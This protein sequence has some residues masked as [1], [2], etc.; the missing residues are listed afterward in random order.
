MRT[1]VIRFLALACASS[2]ALALS[3]NALATPRLIISGGSTPGVA[4]ATTVQVTEDKTD[5]APLKITIYQ[6]TGYTATLGQPAG[7]QIGTVHADL[8]ALAI[9]P[10]A[11]IQADGTVLTANPATYTSN[12]CAPGNHA[13]VWLLHVTV[14]GQTID[15]PVYLD[16]TTGAEAALG[17]AKLQLCLSDPYDTAPA[18]IRAPFGVKLINAKLVLDSGIITNPSSAG[19]FLWRATITPWNPATPAPD[20]AKTVEVQSIVTLPPG[21]ATVKVTVK[22]LK[23]PTRSVA[24][25]SGKVAEN[26]VAVS[27]ASVVIFANGKKVATVKTNATGSYSKSFTIKKATKFQAKVTA[28]QHDTACVSPLPATSVPGGCA[29]ATIAAWAA[30]SAT[31]SAKPKK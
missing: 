27:G 30:S 12:T 8:Q 28:A 21:R 14:S 4:A 3:A 23:K 20:A 29:G 19:T 5:A 7:T 11:I 2:A 24:T 15:V 17:S 22:K 31:V 13:A 6:A 1:T 16:P 10:D 26:G 25:V 18:A 9:S